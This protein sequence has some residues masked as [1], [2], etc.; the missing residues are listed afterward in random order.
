ML[1]YHKNQ[2]EIASRSD[3]YFYFYFSLIFSHIVNENQASIVYQPL[4]DEGDIS[5]IRFGVIE[6]S[7]KPFLAK[8]YIF[9]FIFPLLKLKSFAQ[10]GAD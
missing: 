2:A 7:L 6:T 10:V 1:V 9:V 8:S 4:T 3:T 5:K